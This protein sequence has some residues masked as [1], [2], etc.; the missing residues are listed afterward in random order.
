MI[1]RIGKIKND[2]QDWQNVVA[3]KQRMAGVADGIV[4]VE[5]PV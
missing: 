4:E 5:L 2:Y 1:T 3:L